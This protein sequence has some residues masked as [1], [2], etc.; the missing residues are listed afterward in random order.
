M[1]REKSLLERLRDPDSEAPR[2]IRENTSRLTDS[3]LANLK[4]VLNSRH[5]IAMI[6]EDYGIPDIS[7]LIHSF[8]EANARMRLAVKTSIEKFEPRLRRVRVKSVENED[9]PLALHLEITAELVTEDE[10][11]SVAFETKITPEGEV[12]LRR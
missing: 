2:T 8:P 6:R 4:R 11:A 10:R 3:V 1:P 5:G 12:T 7:D 9:E